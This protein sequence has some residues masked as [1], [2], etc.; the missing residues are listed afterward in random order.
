VWLLKRSLRRGQGDLLLEAHRCGGP[1]EGTTLPEA[2]AWTGTFGV[3]IVARVADPSGGTFWIK[4]CCCCL[5][6]FP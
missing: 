2:P 5:Y 6:F 4:V 3:D 1:F